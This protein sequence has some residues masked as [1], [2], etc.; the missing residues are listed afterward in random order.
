MSYNDTQCPHH[1]DVVS[2]TF[3]VAISRYLIPLKKTFIIRFHRV[4]VI[5]QS[6][7][8]ELDQDDSRSQAV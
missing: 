7:C 1:A 5:F 8:L 3:H 4:L 2:H 6:K